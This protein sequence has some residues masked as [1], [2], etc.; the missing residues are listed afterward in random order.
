MNGYI[1]I[2][3]SKRCEVY[4]DTSFAAQKLAAQK[5]GAKKTYEVD[6]FLAEK[7]GDSVSVSPSLLPGA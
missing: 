1:A 3:K 4:A 7:S 5:L 2:W 6:V